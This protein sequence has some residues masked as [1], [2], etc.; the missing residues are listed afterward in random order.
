[1]KRILLC[2][3]DL[4]R[5]RFDGLTKDDQEIVESHRNTFVKIIN[6]FI[7]DEVV[8]ALFYSRDPKTLFQAKNYF[9]EIY[10]KIRFESRDYVERFLESNKNDR[11]II[12]SGKD[13]DLY[14]SVHHKVLLIAPGWI[15]C[16]DK[17]KKY[18]IIIDFPS[19]I[20]Q[21]L[22]VFDN[23]N[24]WF[25]R[26]QVDDKTI[27]L[28]LMDARYKFYAK[29]LDEREIML[30]FEEL[31]KQGKS[32]NYYKVLMYHFLAGMTGTDFFDDIELFGMM[33]S[34]D[35]SLNQEVFAFM[36]QIRYIQGKQLPHR[37]MK[38]ENLLL[39]LSPKNQAHNMS[40]I[41]RMQLGPTSEFSTLCVNPEFK[42]K[43]EKLKRVKKFNVCIFDDYVT[44]GNSFNAV[45]N[46][47]NHL[48]VDKLVF[49]S[50]G[51]FKRNIEL[52]DYKIQGNV[53]R[54]GYKYELVS[55]INKPQEYD[56]KAKQEV[57]HLYEIFNNPTV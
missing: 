8:D 22:R 37:T 33:P 55:K 53:F 4:L 46:I 13:V 9:R 5:R 48:G 45:R 16:E 30:H 17:V 34:S 12:V 14:M 3:V 36:Q 41:Y 56:E 24:T 43:I 10:P 54:S 7:E 47:F 1:M 19:Q 44:Y 42:D 27:L 39:R 15:P 57:A 29:T 50:L 38:C 28:S 40:G 21:L 31:L 11:C 6:G 52:W 51:N 25:S 32:R 2:N 35:C 23:Q 49:I 20:I 26:C 18:G